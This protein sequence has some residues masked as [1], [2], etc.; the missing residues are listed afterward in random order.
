MSRKRAK[1]ST[2]AGFSEVGDVLLD[3]HNDQS[4]RLSSVEQMLDVQLGADPSCT[5]DDP[6][7]QTK[8]VDAGHLVTCRNSRYGFLPPSQTVPVPPGEAEAVPG[9]VTQGSGSTVPGAA[10]WYNPSSLANNSNP[11][12]YWQQSGYSPAGDSQASCTV[13]GFEST[14]RGVL[15]LDYGLTTQ[16]D[17]L[18][19]TYV[20]PVTGLSYAGE[21]SSSVFMA[22]I[23]PRWWATPPEIQINMEN[24]APGF[25][26]GL[27][28]RDVPLPGSIENW[29]SFR[30]VADSY[31]NMSN[32][33]Q[34]MFSFATSP[35][36]TLPIYVSWVP[37]SSRPTGPQRTERVDW[38]LT[39]PGHQYLDG[40][41]YHTLM[42][43]M[44]DPVPVVIDNVS[45]K[46]LV[47]SRKDMHDPNVVGPPEILMSPANTHI[48]PSAVD[49]IP[50]AIPEHVDLHLP[51]LS[52]LN[53][54]ADEAWKLTG[55][56][57]QGYY[58]Y[59][60]S[61]ADVDRHDAFHRILVAIAAT[62]A[63][64]EATILASLLTSGSSSPSSGVAAPIVPSGQSQGTEI[65]AF[66][67]PGSIIEMGDPIRVELLD[68]VHR[69]PQVKVSLP[70][71]RRCPKLPG[72][73]PPMTADPLDRTA[74]EK[75]NGEW[76]KLDTAA[77]CERAS[78]NN[79]DNADVLYPQ[80][81][82]W[83]DITTEAGC[84]APGVGTCKFADAAIHDMGIGVSSVNCAALGGT[85]YP[86]Q[87]A[88]TG[89]CFAGPDTGSNVL[90][91]SYCTVSHWCTNQC[92]IDCA[93]DPCS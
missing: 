93:V 20:D 29:N 53:K 57:K 59:V 72:T 58:D 89:E 80:D 38:T 82:T 88:D 51:E 1:P 92:Y 40:S 52:G 67:H 9:P 5:V 46:R 17:C 91:E 12:P 32:A 64:D 27:D 45:Y 86:G 21:W 36:G 7:V 54:Y 74:C 13:F 22:N 71:P 44:V 33:Q 61:F 79:A 16:A 47:V 90:L 25:L 41:S 34:F 48:L 62:P 15:G 31:A 76:L 26:P 23:G 11:D 49:S 69:Y 81:C 3:M 14:Q 39:I 55:A 30:D 83:I 50:S 85:W 77:L 65:V 56:N 37:G 87:W 75:L 42:R 73:S 84:T 66:Y 24:N 4:A 35:T 18:L 68:T 2:G 60:M 78:R 6:C 70:F 8:L 28:S 19:R 10:A 43:G 63:A